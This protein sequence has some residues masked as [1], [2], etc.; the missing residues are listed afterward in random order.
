MLAVIPF[1]NRPKH[2]CDPN[3]K[4]K[5]VLF[6]KIVLGKDGFSKTAQFYF[7][8]VICAISDRSH[9]GLSESLMDP[10]ERL[11]GEKCRLLFY[12]VLLSKSRTPSFLT[13]STASVF[14]FSKPIYRPE[15][16]NTA[17]LTASAIIRLLVW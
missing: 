2:H 7:K 9:K 13:I 10:P 3:V 4:E 5:H 6:T 12:R 16:S 15:K 11:I 14:F 17:G 1:L 8:N